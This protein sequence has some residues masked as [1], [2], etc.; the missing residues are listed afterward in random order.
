M[1][2][3]RR[4]QVWW[5]ELQDAGRRPYL[6]MTRNAAIGVLNTVLAAPVT[7]TVR[8]IP[9]EL[10][11]GP[12]DGMP[13]DCAASFDNLTVIPQAF[14]TDH[15]CTLDPARIAEACVALGAATEC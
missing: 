5:G 3:L 15:I 13:A 11:L 1:T 9:T 4:G 2:V 10:R 8:G 7:R 14:L 12:A 6:I